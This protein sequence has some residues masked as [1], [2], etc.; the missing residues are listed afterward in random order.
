VEPADILGQAAVY[1]A[2]T[3]E[4]LARFQHKRG[5]S[6]DVSRDLAGVTCGHA[7]H[8][9]SFCCRPVLLPVKHCTILHANTE[10]PLLPMSQSL[11]H[12]REFRVKQNEKHGC[13]TPTAAVAVDKAI[14]LSGMGI[15]IHSDV[16]GRARDRRRPCPSSRTRV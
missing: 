6:S 5:P 3:G 12:T 8:Y 14:C 15:V 9:F 13:V 1:F 4:H 11:E 16:T 10:L 2:G 7:K